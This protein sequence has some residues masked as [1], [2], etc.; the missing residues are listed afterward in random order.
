MAE[1]QRTEIY[2]LVD[3]R[4][5]LIYYVGRSKDAEKRKTQHVRD[6]RKYYENQLLKPEHD[7][8]DIPLAKPSDMNDREYS[9]I[10]KLHWIATL[11]HYG[12]EPI[13]LMLDSWDETPSTTDAN[14]LEDA[15]IAEMRQRGQPLLNYIYSHRQN[16]SWYSGAKKGWAS[17][18]MEYVMKLKA[19]EVENGK[20]KYG[21][22]NNWRRSRRNLKKSANPRRYNG[23]KRTRSKQ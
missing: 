11:I 15:W 19:G 16:P 5:N 23:R 21:K 4:D 17:S 10:K 12:R 14:R 6:A 20:S 8:F 22:G 13:M 3:P 2:A 9:N 18:P 7:W 1:F